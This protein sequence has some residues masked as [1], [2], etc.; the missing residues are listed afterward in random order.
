MTI[1]CT[2]RAAFGDQLPLPVA[3]PRLSGVSGT[4]T[5]RRRLQRRGS[6]V[7]RVAETLAAVN[8]LAGFPEELWPPAPRNAAQHSAIDRIRGLH[9]ERDADCKA[10][11]AFPPAELRRLLR[12]GPL[13]AGNAV[14]VVA[15]YERGQV[16]LPDGAAEPCRLRDVV[17][18]GLRGDVASLNSVLRDEDS[19]GR[20]VEEGAVPKAYRDPAFQD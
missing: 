14:G 12:E 8:S 16:S 4:R 11:C 13:Y 7:T 10:Y 1:G 15:D 9:R 19:I 18:E 5:E 20:V 17:P 2:P 6:F 3:A